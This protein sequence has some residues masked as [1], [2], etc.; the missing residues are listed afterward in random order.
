MEFLILRNYLIYLCEICKALFEIMGTNTSHFRTI[1][2]NF[3]NL[4]LSGYNHIIISSIYINQKKVVAVN[5]WEKCATQWLW[6]LKLCKL[7]NCNHCCNNSQSNC[8]RV[9]PC[10]L[11][12]SSREEG[13]VANELVC[14]LSAPMWKERGF[15]SP[16]GNT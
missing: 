8:S 5:L 10:W 15:F 13:V 9:D 14:S 6:K 3:S 7:Q 11:F 4:V 12:F 16:P 2:N 1:R